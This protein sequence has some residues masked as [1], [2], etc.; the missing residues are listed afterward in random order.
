M[1]SFSPVTSVA[2]MRRWL[3]YYYRVPIIAI[4]IYL[5]FIFIGERIMKNKKP[6]NMRKHLFLWN[7]F[8]AIFSASFL[9][10]SYI[11][12]VSV[13]HNTDGL[14]GIICIAEQTTSSPLWL[15]LFNMSKLF[16]LGDTVFLVLRKKPVIFLHWYHHIT[17]LCYTWFASAAGASLGRIFAT[18]NA[19]VHTLMYTYYA[20]QAIDLKAPKSISMSITIIQTLQMVIG[21]SCSI[22]AK[23]SKWRGDTCLTP[24]HLIDL[25]LVMYLSY[26]VLFIH[27]FIQAYIKGTS[28]KA[29]IIQ[30]KA[31]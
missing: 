12:D 1:E 28:F 10:I 4:I 19:F 13:A 17:V 25:A 31:V 7:T 11:T 27:F 3:N 24:H 14:H 21:L 5:F 15:W 8:L 26:F 6:F 16:E 29:Q 23:I 2:N 18:T 30:K 9:C 22:Y 20:L